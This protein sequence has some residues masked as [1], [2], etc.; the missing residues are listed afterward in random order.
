ML[1]VC[2]EKS[3]TT[4]KPTKD[5]ESRQ[6]ERQR[7]WVSKGN[8]TDVERDGFTVGV[9]TA[10]ETQYEIEEKFGKLERKITEEFFIKKY[11]REGGCDDVGFPFPLQAGGSGERN[12]RVAA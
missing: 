6:R 12:D 3:P 8:K 5:A 1:A 7:L 10:K 9:K 11:D 2:C 4:E